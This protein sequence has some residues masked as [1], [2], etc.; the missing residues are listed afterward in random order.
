MTQLG[1]QK[2]GSTSCFE[3]IEA[4]LQLKSS[5]VNASG[6]WSLHALTLSSYGDV[7]VIYNPE[8]LRGDKK[9][10]IF[11]GS[12]ETDGSTEAPDIVQFLIEGSSPTAS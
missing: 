2:K 8:G 11:N 1:S 9:K 7:L 6:C 3:G 12:F 4:N 5:W 10:M